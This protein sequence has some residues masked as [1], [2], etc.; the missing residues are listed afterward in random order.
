MMMMRQLKISDL[1]LCV[2][3]NVQINSLCLENFLAMMEQGYSK[4]GNPYHNLVHAADVTQTTHAIITD[5]GL[6]VSRGLPRDFFQR[7]AMRG[8]EGRK[9][10]SRVQGLLPGGGLG[11]KPTEAD[12]IFSK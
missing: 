2:H 3:V 11:V 12:N 4:H 9:S 7:W 1:L 6:N 5:S 8:S 10:P